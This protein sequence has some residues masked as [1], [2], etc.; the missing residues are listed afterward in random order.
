MDLFSSFFIL[1]SFFVCTFLIA[2]ILFFSLKKGADRL[3]NV[4]LRPVTMEGQKFEIPEDPSQALPGRSA[5][6]PIFG[7]VFFSTVQNSGKKRFLAAI[8]ANI[9]WIN[10][11]ADLGLDAA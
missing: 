4:S 8:L 2:S 6:G 7:G 3:W 9:C 5:Y 11:Q 1:R 10:S